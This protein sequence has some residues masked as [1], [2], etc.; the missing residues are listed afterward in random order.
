M[1]FIGFIMENKDCLKS[2]K[3]EKNLNVNILSMDLTTEGI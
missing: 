1:L 3:N 2:I